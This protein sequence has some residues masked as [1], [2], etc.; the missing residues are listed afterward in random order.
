MSRHF[1]FET[2]MS[3]TGTNADTRIPIKLSEEGP[4][5]ITLYNAITGA[6]LPGAALPNNATA[7]KAIKISS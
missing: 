1:Q 4:A 3:L 6:T 7:D 2:G 5:L